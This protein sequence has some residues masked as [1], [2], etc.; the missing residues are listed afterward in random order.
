MTLERHPAT[1]ETALPPTSLRVLVSVP[2]QPTFFGGKGKPVLQSLKRKQGVKST[3][4]WFA[5]LG[6]ASTAHFKKR[7]RFLPRMN[8]GSAESHS[9]CSAM[10]WQ[11][12][13]LIGLGFSCVQFCAKAESFCKD[14]FSEGPSKNSAAVPHIHHTQPLTCTILSRRCRSGNREE[15]VSNLPWH[16][17]FT[18]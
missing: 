2:K 4:L 12:T 1:T 6:E 18:E 3:K 14:K 5:H 13:A 15:N 11:Q 17:T 7:Y 10:C 8:R 9:S 16:V